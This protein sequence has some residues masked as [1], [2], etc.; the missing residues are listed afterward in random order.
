MLCLPTTTRR[1]LS[2]V[3][4]PLIIATL[5]AL[6]FAFWNTEKRQALSQLA[7]RTRLEG[8][9]LRAEIEGKYGSI[10]AALDRLAIQHP[11]DSPARISQWE[12]DVDSYLSSFDGLIRILWVDPSYTIQRLFPSDG[13]GLKVGDSAQLLETSL[14]MPLLVRAARYDGKF[15]GFIFA[16][17]D[18]SSLLTTTAK[19]TGDRYSVSVER[20]SNLILEHGETAAAGRGGMSSSV[21][22]DLSDAGG[23]TLTIVPTTSTVRS[24]LADARSTLLIG[25]VITAVMMAVFI[26]AQ[27]VGRLLIRKRLHRQ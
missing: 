25:L 11:P 17:I 2:F 9:A 22:V 18:L 4:F 26:I 6:T 12:S 24:A 1:L 8:I 20:G 13:S 27:L 7:E 16:Q 19:E 23:L 5:F 15:V 14:E 3:V 21:S 10:A